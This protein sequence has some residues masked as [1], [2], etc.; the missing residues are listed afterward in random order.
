MRSDR[1]VAA[2]L[3][4]LF[5]VYASQIGAIELDLWAED[6][7]LTAR[8]LPTVLAG[9][10]IVLAAALLCWPESAHR[11]ARLT[12]PQATRL[13]ALVLA[14]AV[15]APAV[16]WLGL[17]IAC[18]LFLLVTQLVEGQRRVLP[19]LALSVGCPTVL[20]LLLEKVLEQ[21]VAAGALF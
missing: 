11:M 2:A 10:G 1:L 15:F 7:F 9:L 14:L 3:L 4:A 18:G 17:W 8:T 16:E 21:Q 5:A 13:G 20:W 19:L 12:R 6:S